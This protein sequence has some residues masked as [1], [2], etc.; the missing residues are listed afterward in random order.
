[1]SDEQQQHDPGE[2]IV[3]D[4][5]QLS[6]EDIER[7]AK[8]GLMFRELNLSEADRCKLTPAAPLN[9]A[10]PEELVRACKSSGTESLDVVEKG[11]EIRTIERNTPEVD[12]EFRITKDGLPRGGVSAGMG[13]EVHWQNGP[14]TEGGGRNGAFIEDLLQCCLSRLEFFQGTRFACEH[15][16]QAINHIK[17]AVGIL[18]MRTTERRRRGVEGTQQE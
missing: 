16:Q 5:S 17:D 7:A 12:N 1:M 15:N 14:I 4:L 9:E 18:N 3:P 10:T 8:D 2:T 11:D 13:F 6:Q